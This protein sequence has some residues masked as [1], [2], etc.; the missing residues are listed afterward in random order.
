MKTIEKTQN[1]NIQENT[2]M[3]FEEFTFWTSY[4]IPVRYD[5]ANIVRLVT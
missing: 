1:R 3:H 4:V 2:K 5:D